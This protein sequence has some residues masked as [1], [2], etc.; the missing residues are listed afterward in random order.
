MFSGTLARF[1]AK[2]SSILTV[3]L[4]ERSPVSFLAHGANFSGNF[5]KMKSSTNSPSLS[6]HAN[7]AVRSVLGTLSYRLE[8]Q[9]KQSSR[10]FP[11]KKA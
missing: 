6:R 7:P 1:M 10:W 4:A 2:P 5:P 3:Y 11:N 8:V 9:V